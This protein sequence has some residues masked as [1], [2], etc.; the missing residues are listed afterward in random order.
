MARK[1][2]P[3]VLSEEQ[4]L[5]ISK[6]AAEGLNYYRIGKR[7]GINKG[8]VYYY[9]AKIGQLNNNDAIGAKDILNRSN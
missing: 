1:G 3:S 4:R 6:L 2:R 9:L 8:T 7:L 5:A